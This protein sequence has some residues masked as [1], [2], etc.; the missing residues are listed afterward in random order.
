MKDPFALGPFPGD[1]EQAE[2]RSRNESLE[3][4]KKERKPTLSDKAL[5]YDI[6]DPETRNVY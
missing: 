5:Q 2:Q 3:E 1:T 6:D 4:R